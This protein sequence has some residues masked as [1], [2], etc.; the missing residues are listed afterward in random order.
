MKK[1]ESR[2]FSQCIIIERDSKRKETFYFK[3]KAK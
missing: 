2:I 1:E 3:Y